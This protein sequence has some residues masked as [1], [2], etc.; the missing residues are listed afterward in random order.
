MPLLKRRELPEDTSPRAMK[1]FAMAA[2]NPEGFKALDLNADRPN[3]SRGD[4]TRLFNM[5]L[6]NRQGGKRSPESAGL[7]SE[8][9]AADNFLAQL[10]KLPPLVQLDRNVSPQDAETQMQFSI[11]FHDAADLQRQ[12]NGG[13]PLSDA[14]YQEIGKRLIAAPE[15]T[16]WFRREHA[17]RAGQDQRGLRAR[18]GRRRPRLVPAHVYRPHDPLRPPQG[19]A[20]LE[21]R[22]AG[23]SWLAG[24]HPE[25]RCADAS[26]RWSQGKAKDGS[27]APRLVDR[28]NMITAAMET[29]RSARVRRPPQALPKA[30][31]I[32]E[33][34]AKSP[35]PA[36]AKGPDVVPEA[37]RDIEER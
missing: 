12:E 37:A 13:K 10:E 2:D 36:K 11:A 27:A 3:V 28:Y 20:G 1:L 8:K 4:F 14:D 6:E 32:P 9:L 26:A 22:A 23:W 34:P 15:V 31:P 29:E 24:L 18:P 5:Q 17:G 21:G 33:P 30:A 25:G 16:H 7:M 35:E 19:N